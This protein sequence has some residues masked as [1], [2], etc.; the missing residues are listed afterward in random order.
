MK[1]IVKMIFGSHLYCTNTPQSDTDY[2]SIFVPPV[3]DLL[4]NRASY[5]V[6]NTTKSD[7]TAKNSSTDV[8]NDAYSIHYFLDMACQGN[9]IAI[10]MLHAPKRAL[11]EH[12]WR[13]D[14]LQ[15]YRSKFYTKNLTS[16][17]GYVKHQAAK[18]GVKGSRLHDAKIVLEILKSNPNKLVA[19]IFEQLPVTENCIKH[20]K[21]NV[22]CLYEACSKKLTL[23][24]KCS[25]YIDPL[26]K[27]IENYGHRAQLAER[28]E[29][30]DW[31]AV[32]HAFRAGYQVRSILVNNDFGYPLEETAL[33]I[34]VKRGEMPYS[35]AG[36]LLDHLLDEI[37]DLREKSTL[38]TK[39]DRS[40]FDE[41]LLDRFYSQQ[42]Y[43]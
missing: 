10:D 42:I 35:D 41:W 1:P 23:T 6:K 36:P 11:L 37:M 2:K 31:K 18:Y 19:E 16:L 5:H 9:T 26:S 43:S 15:G 33:I 28:N 24:A 20:Y 32:S 3:K 8:D 21:E 13:W 22:A 25:V 17:V 27:F 38:P 7:E 40:F 4:L 34:R 29:G 12:D 14:E 30:I 39:V